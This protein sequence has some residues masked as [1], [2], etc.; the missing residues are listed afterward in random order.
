MIA[1][2]IARLAVT[3]ANAVAAVLA[4]VDVW[5]PVRANDERGQQQRAATQQQREAEERRHEENKTALKAPIADSQTAAPETVAERTTGREERAPDAVRRRRDLEVERLSR[6]AQVPAPSFATD[7]GTGAPSASVRTWPATTP[8]AGAKLD[9]WPILRFLRK[10]CRGQR[11]GTRQARRASARRRPGLSP[12]AGPLVV[13]PHGALALAAELVK[14]ARRGR[15]SSSRFLDFAAG[16]PFV[17]RRGRL[18]AFRLVARRLGGA[19]FSGTSPADL[20]PRDVS[21]SW[22]ASSRRRRLVASSKTRCPLVASKQ[23]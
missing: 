8:L 21:A 14:L 4:A 3:S 12:A 22:R 9:E 5:H 10:A 15:R 16:R 13:L 23:R 17:R 1:F 18:Q 11:P 7:R 20:P 6:G 2:E 19:A